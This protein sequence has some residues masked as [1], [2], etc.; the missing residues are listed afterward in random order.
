MRQ[1][2]CAF[3]ATANSSKDPVTRPH[4]S[5]CSN[6]EALGNCQPSPASRPRTEVRGRGLR[7]PSAAFFAAI[8]RNTSKVRCRRSAAKHLITEKGISHAIRQKELVNMNL[9][10]SAYAQYIATIGT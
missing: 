7:Q 5:S 3:C 2:L 6:P 8:R 10:I 9:Y 4:R 1:P